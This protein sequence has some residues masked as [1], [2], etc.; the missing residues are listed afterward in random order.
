MVMEK[1][2][3]NKRTIIFVFMMLIILMLGMFGAQSIFWYRIPAQGKTWIEHKGYRNEV[4]YTRIR[5][6]FPRTI[7]TS[8]D[9]ED[10]GCSPN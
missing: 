3:E 10:C 5:G 2:A 4:T 6:D 7:I 1:K 9:E 8:T